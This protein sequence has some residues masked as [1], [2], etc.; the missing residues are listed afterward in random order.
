MG[1]E[2]RGSSWGM[3]GLLELEDEAAA[4]AR[5]EVTETELVER[6]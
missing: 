4:A 6:E 3:K 5:T 2:G 1:R